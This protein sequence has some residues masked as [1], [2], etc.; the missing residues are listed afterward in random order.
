MQ[1]EDHLVGDVEIS[2]LQEL[3]ECFIKQEAFPVTTDLIDHNSLITVS[4]LEKNNIYL[5]SR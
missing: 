5:P 1:K 2:D 4:S 3:T